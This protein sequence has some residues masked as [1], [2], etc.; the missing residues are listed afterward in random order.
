MKLRAVGLALLVLGAC[1]T[2]PRQSAQPAGRTQSA[3]APTTTPSATVGPVTGTER[4]LARWA[5]SQGYTQTQIDERLVWCKKE[6]SIGSRIAQQSCANDA[7]LAA[8][9]QVDEDNKQNLLRSIV[10][11][12]T[13]SSCGGP[14]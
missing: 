7:T 8:M 5:T 11:C 2:T 4:E 3:T 12:P 6:A 10:T 9:R 1:A 13:S 14:K